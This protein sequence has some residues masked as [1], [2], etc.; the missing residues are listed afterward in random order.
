MEMPG[1]SRLFEEFSSQP[2]G[3]WAGIRRRVRENPAA[4]ITA[5]VTAVGIHVGLFAFFASPL[6]ES[7][8]YAVN[9]PARNQPVHGPGERS[10]QT[11]R[12]STRD[13][14]HVPDPPTP[15]AAGKS[16]TLRSS[17][18]N[19]ETE[20][21]P[22][23][24][25]RTSGPVGTSPRPRAVSERLPD[26]MSRAESLRRDQRL[27][28][29]QQVRVQTSRGT[30]YVPSGYFFRSS[31][32]RRLSGEGG[33][34]FYVLDGFPDIAGAE[35]LPSDRPG[36]GKSITAGR[37]SFEAGKGFQAERGLVSGSEF[38]KEPSAV[39]E[40]SGRA[41]LPEAGDDRW[42]GELDELMGLPEIEQVRLFKSRYLEGTDPNS[43]E[44]A[45][46]SGMF[47]RRNLS[48]AF[49]VVSDLS[50][51][52]DFVEEVY[53]N[54][55]LDREFA[56]TW[57]S[58]PG[59][60]TGAAFLL[61][62][63]SHYEFERRA[64]GR[65]FKARAQAAAFLDRKSTTS[66]IHDKREKAK[67]VKKVHDELVRGLE[68]RGFFSLEEVFKRYREEE[69]KIYRLLIE[70][71]GRE[72]EAGLYAL[73]C[74][75]W[76]SRSYEEALETWGEIPGDFTAN[77]ALQEIRRLISDHAEMNDLVPRVDAVLFYHAHKQAVD[78]L[79][80]LVT[81]GRWN[82]RFGP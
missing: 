46:L 57:R 34:L 14:R 74:L 16:Q 15:R 75:R 41:V 19:L 31:P 70:M 23:E 7:R 45:D 40:R 79:V 22:P 12:D 53:Y 48:S 69:E 25:E 63:A 28:G 58:R 68:K 72:R 55:D 20:V 29:S 76:E 2:T 3:R 4:V 54:K 65:L 62:L 73:G 35:V 27:A 9:P 44:M 52:F 33:D 13:Q 6:M 8:A 26:V 61:A 37:A 38:G 5:A 47:V 42:K 82:N 36:T 21:F 67:V 30:R 56:E 80:R 32:Y 59:S 43:R 78:L 64:L 51:A 50:A 24:R 49:V 71:G 66:E 60:R 11:G 39:P 18:R 1:S 17:S 81:F 10:P 77:P